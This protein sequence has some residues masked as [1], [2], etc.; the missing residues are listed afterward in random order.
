M[1]AAYPV[2]VATLLHP[3]RSVKRG[4]KLC[5]RPLSSPP[6]SFKRECGR[7]GEVRA[8]VSR[9]LSIAGAGGNPLQRVVDAG[10]GALAAD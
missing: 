10:E 7:D 3:P 4:G 6:Q 1:A 2:T 5:V 8:R 9:C